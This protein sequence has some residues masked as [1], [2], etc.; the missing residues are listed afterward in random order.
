MKRFSFL[1][2]AMAICFAQAWAYDFVSGGICY[3]K[4][5]DGK[6]VKVTYYSS[7]PETNATY[8][9]GSKTIPSTVTYS[10]TTYSV[11]EIGTYAFRGCSGL[12]SIS[13]PAS[14]TEIGSLALRDCPALASIKVDANNTVFDSRNN[15]N[16]LISTKDNA[17]MVG[18]KNT[19]IPSTVKE[20]YVCAFYH[21]TGLTSITI[22]SSVTYI[23]SQAF[24]KCTS[25]KTINFPSTVIRINDEAFLETP[26]YDS[27]PDGVV[28]INKMLYCYKGK[29][30]AGTSITVKDGTQ[31]ICD[32]A[33]YR[34]D[35]L[36]S[37][38]MPNTVTDIY[39][40]A[41]YW[42]EN[43]T[44][45]KLSNT[46]KTIGNSAFSYCWSLKTLD[47]P[48]S[49]TTIDKYAFYNGYILSITLPSGLTSLGYRAFLKSGI[50]S[51]TYNATNCEVSTGAFEDC[52][53]ETLTIGKGVRKIPENVFNKETIRDIYAGYADP[54]AITT[55]VFHSTCYSN[56][57]LH[58]P[59]KCARY[60]NA[61][62]VWKLFQNIW[63]DN[64]AGNKGDINDDG[65]V[66]VSDVSALIN[67]ILGN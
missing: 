52:A 57:I 34:C 65:V 48:E 45:V 61:R 36:V 17:L 33:F 11:T 28:Y 60:Y 40:S 35:G 22:P 38:T 63:D 3:D 19:V 49:L 12:T 16:A 4:L 30:P 18:C 43:L 55:N 2:L 42:C 24:Y 15:C 46:L 41:F 47:L 50:K 64:G 37:I 10:G 51:V 20:I 39:S 25:L 44:S 62:D 67:M 59:S 21:C 29:M 9:T 6:S 32:N 56:A 26:W 23:G 14:V 66:N 1:L 8:Y 54:V 27:K 5:T 53:L 31:I 13:I 7:T 58:V